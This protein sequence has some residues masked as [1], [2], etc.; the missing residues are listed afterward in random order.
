M[1]DYGHNILS[2][3]VF[4][5]KQIITILKFIDQNEVSLEL[6]KNEEGQKQT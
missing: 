1:K 3:K 2:M 5:A 6:T 4:N